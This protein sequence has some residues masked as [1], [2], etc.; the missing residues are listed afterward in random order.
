MARRYTSDPVGIST[1]VAAI[2]GLGLQTLLHDQPFESDHL[3]A[4]LS[5]AV[6]R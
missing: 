3:K 2:D 5:R 4:V 1:F 6:A